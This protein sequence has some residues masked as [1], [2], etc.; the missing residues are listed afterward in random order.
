MMRRGWF[1]GA[2]GIFVILALLSLSYGVI[3]IPLNQLIGILKDIIEQPGGQGYITRDLVQYLR[4]PHLVLA[5]LIGAGL[6]VCGAVMQAVVRNPMA[7]PYLM[8]VSAGAGTGVVLASAFGY[9]WIVT[10]EGIGLSAFIGALLSVLILFITSFPGYKRNP[11][12]LLLSGLTI[13]IFFSAVISMV[14]LLLADTQKTRSVQFWL[15][16]SLINDRWADILTLSLII[17]PGIIFFMTQHRIL[18]LMLIGDQ[19]SLTMGRNLAVWRYFYILILSIMAAIITALAGII[20]FVGFLVPNLVRLVLGPQHS[21]LV[22]V[23][24]AAGGCF[25]AWADIIGRNAVGG[26]EIPIGIMAAAVGAPV[27][28]WIMLTGRYGGGK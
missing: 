28:L 17:I 8:G 11:L 6:S 4:L 27:F 26:T 9:G 13:N 22:P 12:R 19:L 24:A 25:L 16:G 5:F 7:D 15:M 23:S 14:I 21:F 18:D 3:L 2:A 20:G 10:E 1:W